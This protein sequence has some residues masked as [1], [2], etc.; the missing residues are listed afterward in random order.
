MVTENLHKSHAHGCVIIPPPTH[1]AIPTSTMPRFR[2]KE[3]QVTP[4]QIVTCSHT[5]WDFARFSG[6]DLV[7]DEEALD[8]T[9]SKL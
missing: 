7:S 2:Y 6:N 4:T 3:P 9:H 1:M 5:R 8:L